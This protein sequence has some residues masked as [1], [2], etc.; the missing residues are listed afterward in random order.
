[1]VCFRPLPASS[2]LQS[3]KWKLETIR[4]APIL[5]R[6]RYYVTFACRDW[7]KPRNASV[8]RVGILAEFRTMH[9]PNTSKESGK[10]T[11]P[12]GLC[13]YRL[14]SLLLCWLLFSCLLFLIR[15]ALKPR[16]LTWGALQNVQWCYFHCIF[17]YVCL[18]ARNNSDLRMRKLTDVLF[19]KNVNQ[20]K[21]PKLIIPVPLEHLRLSTSGRFQFIINFG[22]HESWLHQFKTFVIANEGRSRSQWPR[23]VRHELSSPARTLGSWVWILL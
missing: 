12:V 14:F 21:T 19:L 16:P 2:R 20:D 10:Y 11:S 18:S 13:F 17:L 1:V 3:V 4:K 5:T 6:S 7:R 23:R 8:F 9:L 15:L 22:E